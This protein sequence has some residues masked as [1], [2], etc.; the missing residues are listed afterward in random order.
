MN[1]FKTTAVCTLGIILATACGG[2]KEK[3]PEKA[4]TA[5]NM[6]ATEAYE[7]MGTATV[8]TRIQQDDRF[9]TLSRT[10]EQANLEGMLNEDLP[11]TLFAP[12]DTA[13]SQLPAG[14]LDHL[15]EE[16]GKPAL[17][18]L[19]TY[20]IVAG[21]HSAGDISEAI[22]SHDGSYTLETLQG[23]RITFTDTD[24][25]VLLTDIQGDT[26][27]IVR[28]DLRASNGLIHEIDQVMSDQ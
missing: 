2:P 23:K 17:I 13:F 12:S 20:H 21:E 15:F 16:T 4:E 19:L 5:G 7:D 10:L 26:A 24:N 22:K 27:H 18:S 3:S 11:Y 28:P 25:G 14:T 1:L 6:Q 9:N 8:G